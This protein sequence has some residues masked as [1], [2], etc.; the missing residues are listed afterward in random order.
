MVSYWFEKV[1]ANNKG[2]GC[3]GGLLF[4]GL[5]LFTGRTK[6]ELRVLTKPFCMKNLRLIGWLRGTLLGAILSFATPTVWA[7]GMGGGF[8]SGGMGAHSSGGH[9]FAFHHDGGHFFHQHGHFF[10]HHDHFFHNRFFVGF[11]FPYYPYYYYPDD[12]GYYGYYGAPDYADQYWSDLTAAVQTELA[13]AGY[14]HGAIDGAYGPDTAHA[15]Q[16][17]RRGKGLPVN[18]QIDRELL[19]SLDI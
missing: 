16:A 17:Y 12:Y 5:R 10:R 15:V 3:E 1:T 8:H 4:D 2:D 18:S 9:D 11:G 14:Y 6:Q 7:H 13:K 19:K